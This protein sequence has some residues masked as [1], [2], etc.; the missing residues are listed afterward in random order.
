VP[1]TGGGDA[2]QLAL[3]RWTLRAGDNARIGD[4]KMSIARAREHLKKWNKDQEIQEF[5]VS[6]A[7]V[8]LAAK[9][10]HTEEARIAKTLA[11][12]IED[13]AILLVVAG[14]MKIDNR[15]Y[16][17]EYKC[18][19]V[20]LS[21]EEVKDMIGHEIGGVCPFGINEHV[22]VFLDVSLKRFEKV[23]PACGSINSAIPMSCDE[24]EEISLSKKW[25]AVC[26]TKEPNDEISST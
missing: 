2:A 7:T 25:V 12:K 5:D 14:D 22:E 1:P 9:A 8:A 16:K 3:V 17:D 23:Y 11:F 13:R 6:S 21:P 18:K 26:K 4:E 10:L 19:A 24:L 20:M 15:R